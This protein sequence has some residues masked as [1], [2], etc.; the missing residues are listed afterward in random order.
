MFGYTNFLTGQIPECIG[1]LENLTY[2]NLA[3]NELYGEISYFKG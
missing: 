3:W 2:I 1:D